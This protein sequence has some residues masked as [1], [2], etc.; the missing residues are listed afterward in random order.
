MSETMRVEA[1]VDA[2]LAV[3][4]LVPRVEAL[5]QRA[6]ARL[7][8]E[9]DDRR[10]AAEGGGPGAGLEGVLGEGAAERQLHVGV[11]VDPA[12]DDPLAGRV[13]GAVG[14]D[15]EPLADRRDP[16]SVDQDVGPG[17]R[18]RIDDRAALDQRTHRF[19]LRIRATWTGRSTGMIWSAR[20][21]AVD[22]G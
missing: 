17:D 7:D 20:A 4:L 14:G 3:G 10:R 9:V 16:L 2:G 15:V 22:G 8:R 12:G 13:D 19:L 11:G 6:A 21:A 1:V 18:V 5:A